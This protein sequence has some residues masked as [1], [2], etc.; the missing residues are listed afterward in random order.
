MGGSYYYFISS[1]PYLREGQE[2]LISRQEFLA[3]CQTHLSPEQYASLAAIDRVPRENACCESET[4]WNAWETHLR[5]ASVRLRAVRRNQKPDSYIRPE[6]DV[7]AD[8]EKQVMEA[9]D[10]TNPLEE[11]QAIDKMRWQKLSEL[12]VGHQFDFDF[13]VIYHIKLILLEKWVDLSAEK[14][15]Q[16]LDQAVQERI[17][18][19]EF[20][21]Q[22]D[23]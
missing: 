17:P 22:Q 2:P 11:R 21:E 19:L 4:R 12:E 15:Q 13:L 3:Q 10:G 5:N 7:F 18:E 6:L 9:Y 23:A 8:L 20:L 14:G 1:L 16:L